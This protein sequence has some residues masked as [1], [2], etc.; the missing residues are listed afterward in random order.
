MSPSEV[1]MSGSPQAPL[2]RRWV[3]PAVLVTGL[4]CLALGACTGKIQ[5]PS[6]QA[7]GNSP[8][9]APT[10][11]AA[12]ASGAGTGVATGAAGSGVGP[13]GTAGSGAVS[14][15]AAAPDP[16]DAPLTR[17]TQEQYLNTVKDLFGGSIK[18][19]TIFPPVQAGSYFGVVQADVDGVDLDKYQRGAEA[20]AAAVVADKTLLAKVAPC[21]STT[22]AADAHTCATTFLGA[23]ATRLYR[24]PIAAA[25]VARHLALY[26][27]GAANGGYAHGMQLLLAGMLQAPRFLYRV[28]LGTTEAVGATAVK[29]SGFELAARL[30]YGLWSS[31]PDDALNTAAAG[32]MLATPAGVSAQLDR[33]L[34]DPR[35]ATMVPHFLS[36]W[37]HLP[38]LNNVAK[39]STIYPEW[40]DDLRNAMTAQANQFFSDLL[41]NKGGTVAALMTSQTVFM[42]SKTALLYGAS[43]TGLPTDSTFQ[44]SQKTDGTV[45]GLLTLPAFLATQA[46][47]SE[48]SPIYRGKFVREQLFCQELPAPPANVPP[49]PEVTPGVSTR[50]RLKQHEVDMACATCHQM[51]DPIGL[52]FENYDG[53]G[54]YR[55]MDGGKAID[56]S[57]SVSG[58]S[59][60]NG[61]FN[62]P[63]ELGTKL[64][65]SADVES[66]VAKQWFRYAMARAETPADA[67][68]MQSIAQTFHTAGAD[69]R[70]LPGALVVTPAFLYRRSSTL[71]G[72]N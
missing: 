17:L 42:N 59:D 54:R 50:E 45:S 56:A 48:S 31:T 39:S 36:S 12:G 5:G 35:G 9:G 18:L 26:D 40:N 11:A 46:K 62:G 71:G 22:A 23:F 61:P 60:I 33:M 68:S 10:G 72:T 16:G 21:A 8:T 34:K 4:T 20:V 38:D 6:G 14:C 27:A 15:N 67:C 2:R 57:G 24:A 65:K 32:G 63:A 13:T 58:T 51:M 55:T 43:A 3:R 70:T 28:E 49:A 64:A 7:T 1:L 37:I 66:C 53:I 52:G 41:A 69:L 29:L 25:D 30:S 47:A 44:T 19:D